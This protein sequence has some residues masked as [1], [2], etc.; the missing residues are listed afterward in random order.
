MQLSAPTIQIVAVAN[1]L[2][3]FLAWS[4]VARSYPSLGAARF[5]QV[6][7][8]LGT[9]ASA[10][11]L[12]RAVVDPTL[13]F[14]MLGNAVI[15][16]AFCS[17][18]AGIRRFEGRAA[19]WRAIGLIIGVTVVLLVGFK[20]LD[21]SVPLR[22]V[23]MGAA[24]FIVLGLMGRELRNRPETGRSPG[25]EL[26][27]LM[28][29]VMMAAQLGRAASALAGIGGPISTVTFNGPQAVGFI[30]MIFACMMLNFGFVLM[31]IDRLRGEVVALAMV[32]D[33][34]GIANRRQFLV[35]LA[36]S[37]THAQRH[38]TPL[39]LLVVDLDGFKGINDGYGHGAGDACLRAFTRAAQTRL[40]GSDLLA[41]TGGDEFCVLLPAT[42]LDE[43]ALVARDLVKTCRKT[44]ASWCG[45]Q[46]AM[47]ASVGVATWGPEIGLDFEKLITAADQAL[48]AAKKN[49]R[50]RLALPELEPALQEITAPLPMTA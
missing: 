5:W 49:G 14:L 50:D 8:G 48:Y 9:L 20:A 21:D 17:A 24:E 29:A 37:C 35:R 25:V 12:L 19:P 47:T 26:A 10:L 27:G 6:S 1:F 34:T 28:I 4:Y 33:L 44:R 45:E 40:R 36:E 2:A 42:T 15:I 31:A 11:A 22:V 13:P 32:D 30:V 23:T 3:L 46:I 38:N 16:A 43:A 41:R 7:S 18:W 39:S